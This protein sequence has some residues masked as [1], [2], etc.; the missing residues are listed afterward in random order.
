MILNDY[1]R[2]YEIKPKRLCCKRNII[3]LYD[4]IVWIMLLYVYYSDKALVLAVIALFRQ[5]GVE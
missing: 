2:G 3:I 1:K 5:Q 4:S